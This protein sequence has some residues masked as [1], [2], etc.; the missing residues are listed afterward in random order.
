MGLYDGASGRGELASTAHVAKL[1]RAPVVLVLDAAALARSAAAIVHGYASYDPEVDVAGVILNRVGSD[2][3]AEPA[4]RGDRAAR[5]AGARRPAPRRRARRRP[6][7]TSGSCRWPSASRARARRWAR[8]ARRSRRA[9]TSTR[10]CASRTPRPTSPASRGGPIPAPTPSGADR[11]GARARLLLP[12]R[13]EPRAAARRR[14]RARRP[15]PAGRRGAAAAHRRARARRRVPRGLRRAAV[16]QL[17][18]A[19][20]DRRLRRARPAGPGRVRRPAVPRARA[21]RPP[22]VRRRSDRRAT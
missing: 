3:H 18:A 17:G 4:A 12:L 22:D 9:A 8:S 7:A 1:L 14:R 11:R 21:R 19:G 20:R 10:C 13:G 5:R 6:S 15:R 16:G 2:G